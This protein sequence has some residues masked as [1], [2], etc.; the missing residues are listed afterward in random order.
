MFRSHLLVAR[1]RSLTFHISMWLVLSGFM[2]EA[3]NPA[4]FEVKWAPELALADQSQ[5]TRRLQAPFDSPV[6]L[7]HAEQ[8]VQSA[9]CA[10][11]L[12]YR[13]LGF[14]PSSD[15]DASVVQSMAVDCLAI[16][17]IQ[18]AKPAHV[19]F[20]RTFRLG[21][22]ALGLLPPDLAPVISSTDR[23]NARRASAKG[24]FW[25]QFHPAAT[26]TPEGNALAVLEDDTRTLVKI[27]GR[28]DFNRDG[29]DDL[30]VRVDT[31]ALHGTY[32]T[33]RLLLLTRIRAKGPIKTIREFT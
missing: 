7:R 16:Q 27:Y 26:A 14:T 1:G 5:T 20:L 32:R 2:G 22:D 17:A 21:P 24:L 13:D 19:S 31:A 11:L 25:K 30:L 29:I 10:S 23:E 28:G 15:R 9:N 6:T 8:S 4:G 12:R 33:S 3:S 18:L